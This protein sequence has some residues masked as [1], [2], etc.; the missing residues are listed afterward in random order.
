MFMSP[1]DLNPTPYADGN[2]ILRAVLDGARAILGDRFVGMYLYGSLALGD[3]D[4]ASSDIDFLVVT[5]AD[6]P[7]DRVEAL[8][9]LHDR[10]AARDSP[11]ATEIE[12]SYIPRDALRRYDPGHALHPLIDRGGRLRLEQHEIDTVIKLHGLRERGIV[13]AGPPPATL[14]DPVSPDDL[15]H[16]VVELMRIWWAPMRR[17]PTRLRHYGYQVYAVLTMCRTLHTLRHGTVVSKPVA[18]RWAL[19]ELDPRWVPL[20][21]RALAWRKDMPDAVNEGEV[22][23]TQELIQYTLDRCPTTDDVSAAL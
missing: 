13:L 7:A 5:D 12:G 19:A 8:Q 17:D 9:A 21:E 16:A 1:I 11:W 2:A 4:P 3:F 10:I 6:L 15:R 22:R 20:I 14:I 23:A 18:A